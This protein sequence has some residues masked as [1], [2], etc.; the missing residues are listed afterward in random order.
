MEAEGKGHYVGCNVNIHNLHQ[1]CLLYTSARNYQRQG[2][3]NCGRA[4]FS[5]RVA[6]S[7]IIKNF[8]N[9]PLEDGGHY[10]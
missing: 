1:N 7:V 8:Q 3:G 9:I 10:A 5:Q 2:R 4:A 6:E